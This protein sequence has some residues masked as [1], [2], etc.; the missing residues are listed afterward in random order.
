[1]RHALETENIGH[2]GVESQALLA[3]FEDELLKLSEKIP[4]IPK[5]MEFETLVGWRTTSYGLPLAIRCL[6]NG[7][8]RKFT[9]GSKA[10][11]IP[12][13]GS[14][15]FHKMGRG[16]TISKHNNLGHPKILLEEYHYTL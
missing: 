3:N 4:L 9:H 14:W 5:S 8:S 2:V 11:E 12:A 13:S 7:Y 16:R 1:M 6:G 15:L 10:K